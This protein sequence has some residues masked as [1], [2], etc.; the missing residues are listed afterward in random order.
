MQQQVEIRHESHFLCIRFDTAEMKLL[1]TKPLK[2][3]KSKP[4]HFART[5]THGLSDRLTQE[6]IDA[7]K[8]KDFEKD[9]KLAGEILSPG[10]PETT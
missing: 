1:N 4:G 8:E 5:R 6:V 10:L 9:M 7:P 2:T 3:R